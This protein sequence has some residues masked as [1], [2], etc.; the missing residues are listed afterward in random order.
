MGGGSVIF[1][2][3]RSRLLRSEATGKVNIRLK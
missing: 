3:E 2:C 1:D